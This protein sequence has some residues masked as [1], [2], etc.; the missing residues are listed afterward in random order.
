MNEPHQKDPKLGKIK[1]R[2][3]ELQASIWHLLSEFIYWNDVMRYPDTPTDSERLGRAAAFER[4]IINENQV[5]YLAIAKE[6]SIILNLWALLY[7]DG[8]DSEPNL[9]RLAKD[10]NDPRHFPDRKPSRSLTDCCRYLNR[11]GFRNRFDLHRNQFIAHL[12]SVRPCA[13]NVVDY[14][15]IYRV[16]PKVICLVESLHKELESHPSYFDNQFSTTASRVARF[17]SHS[18]PDR[19]LG[20]LFANRSLPTSE[21]EEA[22]EKFLELYV[23][24][25]KGAR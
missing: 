15:H 22:I 5:R 19:L 7:D 24:R 1:A 4:N 9:H 25:E 11:D 3:A 14:S 18:E 16:V 6:D 8:Q 10:L 21:F 20:E 12:S 13:D 2:F 17:F 23:Q